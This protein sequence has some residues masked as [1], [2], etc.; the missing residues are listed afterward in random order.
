[1]EDRHIEEK[2]FNFNKF[3]GSDMIAPHVVFRRNSKMYCIY[4]GGS[5]DT[6]EHCPSRAFLTKP[7]PTN[8]PTLPACKLCNNAF[9]S[10]EKYVKEVLNYLYM[11]YMERK[12]VLSLFTN[13]EC[14][15]TKEHVKAV[16]SF[17]S[18]P[19]FDKRV[20]N[21]FR[22]LAIGHAAY[23]IS[24]GYYSDDWQ[25]EPKCISYAL[26]PM[27]S[28]SEWLGLEYAEVIDEDVLPE[29]GSR[30]FRNIYVVQ[31]P[32]QNFETGE[33]SLL[34]TCLLDWTDVQ[35]DFYKYQVFFRE[36][37]IHVKIIL[38]DFLYVEVV[39]ERNESDT[40]TDENKL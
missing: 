16:T 28:D 39:F 10:D 14:G 36:N 1:M 27:L 37:R 6:R 19:H 3:W 20:D 40:R 13:E 23:E 32:I 30:E 12:D 26:K 34:S 11:Y 21:V 25:G 7:Y 38:K 9:S 33:M 31:M 29:L 5:A 15:V 17:I 24:E 22:K 18:N 35:D 2:R 8:L 4:C